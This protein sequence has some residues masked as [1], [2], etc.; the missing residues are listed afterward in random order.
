MRSRGDGRC[1]GWEHVGDTRGCGLCWTVA[2]EDD[3]QCVS[4]NTGV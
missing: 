3:V 1:L 4:I 2:N